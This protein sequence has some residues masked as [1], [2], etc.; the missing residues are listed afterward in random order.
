MDALN[1]DRPRYDDHASPGEI[2]QRLR[3]RAVA[4]EREAEDAGPLV[5]SVKK[6]WASRLL[7]RAHRLDP[8]T[9]AGPDEPEG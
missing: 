1:P 7:E 4:F 5:G 9:L 6:W 8:R 3:E 2:A